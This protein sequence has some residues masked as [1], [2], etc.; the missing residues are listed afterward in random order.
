MIEK[1]VKWHKETF[2]DVDL[3]SQKMKFLEEY[4]EFLEGYS[5]EEYADM[6]IC[7][8]ALNYRFDFFCYDDILKEEMLNI[9]VA[10]L[11]D[12]IRKKM[13]INKK[14]TWKKINGI[15]RHLGG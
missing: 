1:I 10:Y 14:R 11:N 7:N 2:P 8:A 6:F 15:Y 5:L 4:K 3:K 13:E 9:S 12:A